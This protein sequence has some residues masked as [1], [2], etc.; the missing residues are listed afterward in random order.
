VNAKSGEIL[1]IASHPTFDPNRLDEEGGA[2]SQNQ[3][4]P[5][6]NRAAQGAYLPGTAFEPLIKAQFRE[7]TPEGGQLENFYAQLGLYDAPRLHMPVPPGAISRDIA[8]LRVS[9][10][11]VSLAAAAMSNHGIRPAPRIALA[12]NTL[13]EGWV[14]LPPLGEPSQVIPQEQADETAR[15]YIGSGQAYWEH[16]GQSVQGDEIVT[17]FLAGTIPDWQGTPLTVVVVL[18]EDNIYLAQQAGR[19]LLQAANNP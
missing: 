3:S 11:Q 9:P 17:W 12:V 4:A 5:L 18:E 16:T 8:S 6:L 13:Q 7:I 15:A 1:A 2:L 14:I 19:D 10:L